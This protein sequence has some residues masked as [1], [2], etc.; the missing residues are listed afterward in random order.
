MKQIFSILMLVVVVLL[1]VC[2]AAKNKNLTLV[3]TS[4]GATKDDAIKNA[5]REAVEQTYGVFVSA[6]TD[7]LNDEII[8]DE[9]ATVSSGNIKS[10]KELSVSQSDNKTTVTLEATV[11]VGKLISYAKSKGA[12]VEFDGAS[13]YADIELQELYKQNE[14]KAIETI[15]PEIKN[16]FNQGY[17]Y[18]LEIVQHKGAGY[19]LSGNPSEVEFD[20]YITAKLNPDGELAW[21]KLVDLLDGISKEVDSDDA[22]SV[23]IPSGR[24]GDY[25][26]KAYNLRSRKNSQTI[27]SFIESELKEIIANVYLDFGYQE[28][29]PDRLY[30]VVNYAHNDPDWG[31]EMCARPYRRKVDK[32]CGEYLT[33]I[34]I[35]IEK[36]KKIRNVVVKHASSPLSTQYIFGGY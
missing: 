22:Y 29:I 9:I 3:V 1:P 14:E 30:D 25:Y 36:L 5:L 17:D 35:P 2:T 12:E 18:E 10:Y 4:D 32:V 24:F 23:R 26:G 33:R 16:L 13:M 8:R 15:L 19:S 34:K 6:N 27:Q 7:I 21:E 20:C 31:R 28:V 11:S